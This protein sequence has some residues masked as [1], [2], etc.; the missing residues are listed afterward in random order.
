[1][2]VKEWKKKVCSLLLLAFFVVFYIMGEAN[3]AQK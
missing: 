3:M 2:N 1:M